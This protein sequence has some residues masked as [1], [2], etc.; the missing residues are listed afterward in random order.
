[1]LLHA[2]QG[3]AQQARLPVLHHAAFQAL[4]G[5][6]AP[7]LGER[8]AVDQRLQAGTFQGVMEEVLDRLGDAQRRV[9][10]LDQFQRIGGL[11]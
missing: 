2:L 8:L 1:M 6:L 9:A 11:T 7:A 10:A 3:Q 5:K 4:G